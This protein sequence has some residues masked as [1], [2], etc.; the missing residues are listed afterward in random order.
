MALINKEKISAMHTAFSGIFYNALDGAIANSNFALVGQE[1]PSST[2]ETEYG[3]IR[4][5]PDLEEELG[6]K[7]VHDLAAGEYAIRNKAYSNFI[8]VKRDDM[9]DDNLGLYNSLFASAGAKAGAWVGKMGLKL[10]PLGVTS[11]GKCFDGQPYFSASHPNLVGGTYS[12]YDANG[13]SGTPWYLID[14][15]QPLKPLIHQRREPLNFYPKNVPT[16]DNVYWDE[17]VYWKWRRRSGFGYTLPH[18]AFC[19]R[20]TLNAANFEAATQAMMEMKDDLG[21]ELDIMPRLLVVGPANR[22]AAMKLLNAERNDAG[23][24]N[25]H[26]GSMQLLVSHFVETIPS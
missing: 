9:A 21:A 17:D 11:G 13:G 5:V 10:L 8:R 25:I 19:S 2:S 24:S 1:V 14:T 12:N 20:K 6:E 23:A 22:A 3:W 26:K 15:A 4:S 16:D 18:F 7:R